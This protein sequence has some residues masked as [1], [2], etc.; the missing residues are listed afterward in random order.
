MQELS[1]KQ[2]R[3]TIEVVKNINKNSQSSSKKL[4]LRIP[5]YKKAMQTTFRYYSTFIDTNVM[6]CS[7]TMNRNFTNL[8]LFM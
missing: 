4:E 8:I 3:C 2:Y 6:N 5:K 1:L 7:F